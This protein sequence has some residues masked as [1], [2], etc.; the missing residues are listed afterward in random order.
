M[1]IITEH[2]IA[3][4]ID[5]P[6]KDVHAKMDIFYNPVMISNRNISILLLNTINTKELQIAD[7][8]AGSGIRS[9]RFIK[10]LAAGKIGRLCVNDLK[11]NFPSYFTKRLKDSKIKKTDKIIIENKEASR[12]LLDQAGFDYIDLDP[13]GSP[14]PFLGAAIARLS[15]EG[16]LAITATDTAALTGTYPQVTRRKYWAEPMHNYLMHEIGL[17][18]LIRKIQL[19]GI[20]FDKALTPLLSYHKEHYFRIYFQASKGKEKCDALV[21]QHQYFLH[22]SSCLQFKNSGYNSEKCS[23]G[24]QF[25]VAGPLSIGALTDQKLIRKMAKNNL[26]PEETAFLDLL[27]TEATIP[28]IGYY[29]LHEIARKLKKDPPRMEN[30]LKKI[31]AVR[32]HFSG[33]GIKTMASLEEIKKEFFPIHR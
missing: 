8:L 23:C 30:I 14:N 22:C 27:A 10:E 25:S 32:T 20:Q 11:P 26:F 3:L 31:K 17:R 21:K 16:F 18:I 19:Q 5:L 7:P 9:L 28:Q 13:F 6:S 29:D 15:R 2:S 1:T 33:T 24:K 4:P 12:F